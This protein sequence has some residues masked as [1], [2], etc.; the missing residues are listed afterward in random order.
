[1]DRVQ[2]EDWLHVRERVSA[3]TNDPPQGEMQRVKPVSDSLV[4]QTP[5]GF[6]VLEEIG[7]GAGSVVY[8]AMQPAANNRLVAIKVMNRVEQRL[9]DDRS[10]G[11]NPFQREAKI[12]QLFDNPGIVRIYKTGRLPDGRFYVAMELVDGMTLEQELVHRD[13]IPWPEAAAV[14]ERIASAVACLHGEQIVHRDLK[15]GNVMVR[16]GK[17]GRLRIKLIDFGLAK[18][19]VEWDDDAAGID[20]R[21]IGTPQYMAPEQANGGG[22]TYATDVYAMGAMLYEM[23]CGKPVLAL[24][25]PSADAC[26]NY[27]IQRRPVPAIP[28]ATLVPA[29]PEPI[30]RLLE[31]TLS[32]DPDARPRDAT[33]FGDAVRAAVESSGGA[34]DSSASALSRLGRRIG[35]LFKGGRRRR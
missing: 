3:S 13:R 15:P 14:A 20:A 1:M 22:T 25:R 21:T 28:V 5:D 23:I 26:H 7:R 4:G 29:C 35:G 17:D 18:L 24:R 2:E 16:A 6:V 10:K 30:V 31:G 34:S 33:Y 19:A 27:L 12:A 8:R 32:Y 9:L 11:R